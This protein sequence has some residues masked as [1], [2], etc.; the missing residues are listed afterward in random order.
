MHMC[1]VCYKPANIRCTGCHRAIYCSDVC[2]SH[3]WRNGHRDRCQ[4][5]VVTLVPARIQ[6]ES[7][8]D[9]EPNYIL[10]NVVAADFLEGRITL[11]QLLDK[12]EANDVVHTEI[13]GPRHFVAVATKIARVIKS[14]RAVNADKE[15]VGR[16]V[17]LFE[18][19]Q[20]AIQEIFMGLLERGHTD[21]A[22]LMVQ[23]NAI[24]DLD[25]TW[26]GITTPLVEAIKVHSEPLVAAMLAQGANPNYYP[27]R[28]EWTSSE[29]DLAVSVPRPI[30]TA[31]LEG[32]TPTINLL[33][34]RGVKI[35]STL[36]AYTDALRTAFEREEYNVWHIVNFSRPEQYFDI[37]PRRMEA[38]QTM[39]A[40]FGTLCHPYFCAHLL[41]EHSGPGLGGAFQMLGI[42]PGYRPASQQAMDE[43]RARLPD[44]RP[45]S[46]EPD[47]DTLLNKAAFAL[48][49]AT[50]HTMIRQ[51]SGSDDL[52]LAGQHGLTPL[53]SLIRGFVAHPGKAQG[54]IT[55]LTALSLIMVKL[56]GAS[57][58]APADNGDTILTM[59]RDPEIAF[60]GGTKLVESI[61]EYHR[62]AARES[63][64]RDPIDD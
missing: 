4:P 37:R 16:I 22:K 25:I 32:D 41:I 55:E 23:A 29:Y 38:L 26:M 12:M 20:D 13:V 50:V 44:F 30:I 9:E 45:K 15:L 52:K 7:G 58:M 11:V 6:G 53:M 39:Y 21:V 8:D 61:K 63:R 18:S 2:R 5:P 40:T 54:L 57:N 24:P 28:H 47:N 36:K 42:T 64:V 49:L 31:L 19:N 46:W 10:S 27:R 1:L 17:R 3:H 62:V 33:L 43:I 56:G 60:P 59:L 51:P 14:A 34:D 48:N 35:D